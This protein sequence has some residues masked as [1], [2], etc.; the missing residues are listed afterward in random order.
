MGERTCS[1]CL[2]AALLPHSECISH[3][4]NMALCDSNLT[5]LLRGNTASASLSV[6]W[7]QHSSLWLG[8]DNKSFIC[9]DFWRVS[10]CFILAGLSLSKIQIQVRMCLVQPQKDR[11]YFRD[12][13]ERDIN[14]L[15]LF[16]PTT[17]TI[18]YEETSY[19]ILIKSEIK[20]KHK[21]PFPSILFT[22]IRKSMF[23][24]VVWGLLFYTEWTPMTDHGD[25][26]TEVYLGE[27][28]SLLGLFTIV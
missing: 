16:M 23:S 6:K 15:Q 18:S 9:F 11:G 24:C 2:S 3:P 12:K 4:V 25:N 13:F 1:I 19:R 27:L 17:V 28:L 14:N 21:S 26:C 8:K 7:N 20:S 5:K 10:F 22:A